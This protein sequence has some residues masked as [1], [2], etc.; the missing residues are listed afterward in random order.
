[1]WIFNESDHLEKYVARTMSGRLYYLYGK[2]AEM[3]SGG[4]YNLWIRYKLANR[5]TGGVLIFNIMEAYN[6]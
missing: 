4:I 3:A 1:M 2:P 5:I 6:G